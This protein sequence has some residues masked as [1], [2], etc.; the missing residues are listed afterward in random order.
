MLKLKLT[1]TSWLRYLKAELRYWLSG[2]RKATL[3]EQLK[4]VEGYLQCDCFDPELTACILCGCQV[5]QKTLRACESCPK[6]IPVWTAIPR[7]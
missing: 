6:P 4:R 5:Y 3:N 7:R 1:M 2:R